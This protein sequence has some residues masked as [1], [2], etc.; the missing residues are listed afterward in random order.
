MPEYRKPIVL[1]ADGV[2][3]VV[4]SASDRIDPGQ[5]PVNPDSDNIITNDPEK[6]LT[7]KSEALVSGETGNALCVG[8][9]KKLKVCADKLVKSPDQ[10]LAVADNKIYSELEMVVTSAA[11]LELHGIGG[12]VIASVQLP[13]V[14]GL[15]TMAEFLSD[16]TPPV[17]SETIGGTGA[18]NYLHL[19][20]LMSN[21]ANKD[22]Y[23]SYSAI[24]DDAKLNVIVKP[25]GGLDITP[26]GKVKVN[27]ND[28][29]TSNGGLVIGSDGKLKVNPGDLIT[30]NGGLVVNSADGK[31]KVDFSKLPPSQMQNIVTS[32]VQQGGGIGVDGNGKLY[33]DFG[34]MPTDKFDAMLKSLR[35]PIW[36]TANK[37][38]YVNKNTGSDT[39]DAGRGESSGK[40][41]KTIQACINYVTN[42]YNVGNYIAAIKIA[43]GTYA[44]NLTLPS[45][46]RNNGYISIESLS[47]NRGGVIIEVKTLTYAGIV[48]TSGR[49][50][51]NHLHIRYVQNMSETANYNN[52]GFYPVIMRVDTTSYAIIYDCEFELAH[53]GTP[54]K[55]CYFI[56]YF[57]LW[58]RCCFSPIYRN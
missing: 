17:G 7:L 46:S 5:L 30:P 23:V 1:G 36:L 27:P 25:G 40:P 41:F 13:L 12:T 43:D 29:I 49:Y 38:F 21:G 52:P 18:G 42:N 24:L 48:C 35:L 34:S 20:F 51:F 9:D 8:A 26:D 14:P 54:T 28:I 50:S 56:F 45:Y 19:R 16:F 4:G 57:I 44:E 47:G 6:G 2:T 55:K 53:T 22:L 31:L 37:S 3:H 33:V 39:L 10:L 32:M 15:P 11:K 58:W